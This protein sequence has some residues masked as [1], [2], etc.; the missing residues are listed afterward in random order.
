MY[1]AVVYIKIE[2]SY[3]AGLNGIRNM[4]NYY[5]LNDILIEK[6][7]AEKLDRSNFWHVSFF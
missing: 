4:G 6:G 3:I 2:E 1:L 5:C 7:F